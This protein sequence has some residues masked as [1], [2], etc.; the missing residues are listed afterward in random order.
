[1]GEP[2]DAAKALPDVAVSAPDQQFATHRGAT[3]PNCVDD[4]FGHCGFGVAIVSQILGDAEEDQEIEGAAGVMGGE[5]SDAD[6]AARREIGHRH[7]GLQL[8]MPRSL[9]RIG[10]A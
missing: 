7:G 6:A 2:V 3:V 1:M 4:F 9:P 5:L 8:W 10:R